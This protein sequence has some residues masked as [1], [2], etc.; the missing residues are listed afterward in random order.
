[1]VDIAIFVVACVV[2]FACMMAVGSPATAHGGD[3][4]GHGGHH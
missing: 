2:V 3:D 4:H 1:M